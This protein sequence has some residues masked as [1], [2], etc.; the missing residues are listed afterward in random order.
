MGPQDHF[1]VLDRA[2]IRGAELGYAARKTQ[3]GLPDLPA[4]GEWS[5]W[6]DRLRVLEL[7]AKSRP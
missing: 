4:V 6:L 7:A 1:R 5:E 2:H 3:R